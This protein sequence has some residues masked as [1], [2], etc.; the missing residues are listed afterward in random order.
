LSGN[1]PA[2]EDHLRRDGIDPEELKRRNRETTGR[3]YD[4]IFYQEKIKEY[5]ALLAE[6]TA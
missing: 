6:E 1:W 4:Q 3:K 5:E 2:Y